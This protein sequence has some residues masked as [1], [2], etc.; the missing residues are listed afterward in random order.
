[1]RIPK[2]MSSISTPVAGMAM[3]IL[4]A[5]VTITV[6]SQQAMANSDMAKKTGQ[7]CTKCHTAPPALNDYGKKYKDSLK[8]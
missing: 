7:S 5:V 2:T 6:A 4:I 8:K 1:M 3:V